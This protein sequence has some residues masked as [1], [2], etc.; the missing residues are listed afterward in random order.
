MHLLVLF[1]LTPIIV[2]TRYIYTNSVSL[3][4]LALSQIVLFFLGLGA[5]PLG[6]QRQTFL[7]A[8]FSFEMS[9]VSRLVCVATYTTKT[10]ASVI[11]P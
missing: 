9:D 2:L 5:T 1:I 11:L 10:E 3:R 4:Q 8:Q 7:K 6:N